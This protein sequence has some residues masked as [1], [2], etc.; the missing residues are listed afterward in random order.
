M[1][2]R[3]YRI[4][5]I[6]SMLVEACSKEDAEQVFEQVEFHKDVAIGHYEVVDD[7]G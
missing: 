6:G 4:E 5:F 3:L 7:F 2:K 1:T